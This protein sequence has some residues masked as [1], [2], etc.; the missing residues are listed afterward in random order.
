MKWQLN[1]GRAGNEI[2]F[3]ALLRFTDVNMGLRSSCGKYILNL[4]FQ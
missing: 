2:A 3:S 1:W 4:K